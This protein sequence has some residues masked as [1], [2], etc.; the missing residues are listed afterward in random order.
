M[1]R[2]TPECAAEVIHI[3]LPLIRKPSP[4][5]VAVVLSAK[6]SEPDPASDRQKLPVCSENAN[7][8]RMSAGQHKLPPP[9][10]HKPNATIILKNS[11]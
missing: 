4:S 2:K 11:N 1:T 9:R 6:A 10:L 8:T 3:L 5:G 7:Y